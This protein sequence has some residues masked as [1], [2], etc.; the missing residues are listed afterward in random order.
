MRRVHILVQGI[1]QGVGFR[2]FVYG[3]AKKFGLCGWVLND[4]QGVQIE[5]EGE[6]GT[7]TLRL[8]G[9][10]SLLYAETEEP[11]GLLELPVNAADWVPARL[12]HWRTDPPG[13]SKW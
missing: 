2:P 10:P 12:D 3:L 7:R 11:A 8:G 9:S 5:V 13:A 4:E 1:V 6:E